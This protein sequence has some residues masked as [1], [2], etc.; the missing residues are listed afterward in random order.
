MVFSSLTR[1]IL[2]RFTELPKS[3]IEL[4]EQNTSSAHPDFETA[5]RLFLHTC[6][7]SSLTYIV[8]DALDECDE[9]TYRKQI[10]YHMKR[11]KPLGDVRFFI[12][13]REYPLDIQEAFS[14]TSQIEIKAQTRDLK[15]FLSQAINDEP[16]AYMVDGDFRL[17]IIDKIADGAHGL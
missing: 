10:L 5:W 8:L 4:Y 2:S 16:M 6:A 15:H 11:L 1:Q 12:T 14:Y 3:I 13:S 9:Q 17:R 7:E